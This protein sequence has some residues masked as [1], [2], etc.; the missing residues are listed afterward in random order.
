M[1]GAEMIDGTEDSAL[2]LTAGE[3]VEDRSA[4]SRTVRIGSLCF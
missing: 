2:W 1:N 3:E 4:L